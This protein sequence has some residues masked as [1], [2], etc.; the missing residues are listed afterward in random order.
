MDPTRLLLTFQAKVGIT[1]DL[2][3][4]TA[5]HLA[6]GAGNNVVVKLLIE[7]GA[8]IELKNRKVKGN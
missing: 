5:L 6:A 1:D 7:A 3:G 8:D 4:N 2:M